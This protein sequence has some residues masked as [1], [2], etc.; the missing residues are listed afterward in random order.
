MY[1]DF[2]SSGDEMTFDQDFIDKCRKRMILA[3]LSHCS[4]K[5][6]LEQNFILPSAYTPPIENDDHH[7]DGDKVEGIKLPRFTDLNTNTESMSTNLTSAVR[8]KGKLSKSIC[9]EIRKFMTTAV[10]AN[11]VDKDSFTAKLNYYVIENEPQDKQQEGNKAM[12]IF[13]KRLIGMLYSIP[14]IIKGKKV[15]AHTEVG[16]WNKLMATEIKILQC[17]T[18][19]TECQ[20]PEVHVSSD[21]IAYVVV[22]LP[23]EE[24]H[25]NAI[26]LCLRT[27]GRQ[28]CVINESLQAG[29]V[30]MVA[31]KNADDSTTNCTWNT[32]KCP[33]HCDSHKLKLN[34]IQYPSTVMVISYIEPTDKALQPPGEVDPDTDK[35]LLL[36]FDNKYFSATPC[37][38]DGLCLCYSVSNYLAFNNYDP[39]VFGL[40]SYF[41]NSVSFWESGIVGRIEDFIH[42]LSDEDLKN[43]SELNFMDDVDEG[44]MEWEPKKSDMNHANNNWVIKFMTEIINA[45]HTKND[46]WPSEAHAL[47]LSF[48][49]KI[50]IIIIQDSCDD[51]FS[52]FFDSTSTICCPETLIN[53][54]WK[55]KKIC[56]IRRCD[57]SIPE[58]MCHWTKKQIHFEYLNPADDDIDENAKSDAYEGRGGTGDSDLHPLKVVDSCANILENDVSNNA[59]AESKENIANV[60]LMPK[61]AGEDVGGGGSV[62][63]D[64]IGST[65]NHNAET[66][67]LTKEKVSF[68][69]A[70]TVLKEKVSLL[71]IGGSKRAKDTTDNAAKANSMKLSDLPGTVMTKEAKLHP[72]PIISQLEEWN[73]GEALSMFQSYAKDNNEESMKAFRDEI[74]IRCKLA[75]VDDFIVKSFLNKCTI[76]VSYVDN[77]SCSLSLARL[78]I[79]NV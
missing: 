32:V 77:Q 23:N 30:Y 41:N 56:Y 31:C 1:A 52:P 44:A 50:R 17:P 25:R 68:H 75:R 76:G 26:E 64:D 60:T 69:N 70:E 67:V 2:L 16:Q 47:I 74:S 22:I 15:K 39:T 72:G 5:D 28:Y 27:K 33:L 71:G 55:D 35:K 9:D 59:E 49:F 48:M 43:I 21:V 10:Q 18:N 37:D 29:S 57:G 12:V 7:D 54:K 34:N 38:G 73:I 45:L 78:L 14:K 63:T 51:G 6:T 24:T 11:D 62:Q 19:Q 4:I 53:D 8:L 79:A 20:I 40:K 46:K 66:V 42:A 36:K 13:A 3:I 65:L 61:T 58:G